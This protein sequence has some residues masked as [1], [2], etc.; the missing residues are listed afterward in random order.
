M[1]ITL[2]YPP[3]ELMPN[4]ANGK[5]WGQTKKIKAESKLAACLLTK[6]ALTK[7]D[8]KLGDTVPLII[9]YVRHDRRRIDADGLL[10][11]SKHM[12]DGVAQ[13]LKID[14]SQFEPITI[15]RTYVKTGSC[16]IIEVG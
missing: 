14:D 16:T 11:A 7:H 13:A 12:L 2:P 15:K 4:R 6:S 1:I 9:T 10:S 3:K 8:I 5:H